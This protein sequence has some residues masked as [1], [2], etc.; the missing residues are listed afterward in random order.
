MSEEGAVPQAANGGGNDLRKIPVGADPRGDLGVVPVELCPLEF[1]EI[2]ACSVPFLQHGPVF[3]W[4]VA[5]E[6]GDGQILKETG[7]DALGIPSRAQDRGKFA[8]QDA[9][10]GSGLPEPRG[11]VARAGL[12][13][14]HSGNAYG[15]NQG[16]HV[17]LLS[18][19]VGTPRPTSGF[20]RSGGL[21][22]TSG[23]QA[24]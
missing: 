7:R 22:A 21:P 2:A 1:H 5:R 15:Q 17:V 20:Y 24:A 18:A 14:H 11:I 3:L 8:R 19:G 23:D 10:P 6:E 12:A 16:P 4:L 13:R 9:A